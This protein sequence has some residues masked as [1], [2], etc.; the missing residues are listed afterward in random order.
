M[1]STPARLHAFNPPGFAFAVA[2]L[3][4]IITAFNGID[5]DLYTIIEGGPRLTRLLG[6]MWPL[7]FEALPRL[8]NSLWITFLMAICGTTLGIAVSLPLV[9]FAARNLTPHPY[10][11]FVVRAFIA[12]CRTVPDLIWALIFVIVVGLGPVAGA[13]AIMMDS[14]G[15]LGKFFSE[16]S[17]E[18]DP[19][20]QEAVRA[21]GG[22][23]LDVA[24]SVVLPSA[25]P[26][27]TSDALFAMEKA[28][29]ASVILGLVGAGGIGIELKVAID[30]FKYETAALIILLIFSLVVSVEQVS[31]RLRAKIIG[32]D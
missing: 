13:L 24:M 11:R 14:I 22:S 20:P 5:F 1:T 9:L 18:Q 25:M 12:L 17:E 8:L 6:Q 15:F 32:G 4:L 28:V 30:L 10:I 29:R 16:A 31:N 19:G 26:A 2:G 27:F 7:N 3:A 21:M 23:R